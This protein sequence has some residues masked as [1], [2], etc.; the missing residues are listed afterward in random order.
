MGCKLRWLVVTIVALSG[1]A[2]VGCSSHD[3]DDHGY[4]RRERWDDRRTDG[5][6]GEYRRGPR[7]ERTED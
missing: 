4:H 3:D 7:G 6:R 5:D 1:V 2:G